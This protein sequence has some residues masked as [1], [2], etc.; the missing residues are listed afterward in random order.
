MPFLVCTTYA[1]GPNQ[2]TEFE[3]Y[4]DGATAPIISPAQTVTGGV[5]LHY[6]VSAV[7]NGNHTVT[8]QAVRVDA[9]WGRLE[10]AASAPFAFTKPS[11][12][13]VP[14]GIGLVL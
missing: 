9:L 12:P 13:D 14:S 11:A 2:P 6:D 8:V 10:S 7:T 1:S 4:L 3:V 5:R